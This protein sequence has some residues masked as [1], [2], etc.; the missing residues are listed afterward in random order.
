MFPPPKMKIIYDFT[1]GIPPTKNLKSSNQKV[2][3]LRAGGRGVWGEFRPPSQSFAISV[4]ILTKRHRQ[5]GNS[6]MDKF[7]QQKPA[8]P[9]FS[10][11]TFDGYQF[12]IRNNNIEIY[13]IDSKLGHGRKVVSD[14]I[15]HLYY[16]LKG[17]VEFEIND[18]RYLSSAGDLIEIPPGNSFNYKGKF[19]ALLIM[20]PP[21]SPEKIKGV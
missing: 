11:G 10:R 7:I 12:A 15:T 17:K 6:K 13:F 2:S 5:K 18:K 8:T 1:C 3:L 14:S 16:I 4:R 21:Y 20:E 9:S 19:K